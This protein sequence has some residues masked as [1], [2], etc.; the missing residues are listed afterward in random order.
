M[1]AVS[2]APT[3]PTNG[4]PGARNGRGRFGSVG[5]SRTTASCAAVKASRT[6]KLKRLA[7][8]TEA[9]PAASLTMS[10]PQA[11]V[12]VV[13]IDAGAS[14]VRRFSRSKRVREHAV[15]RQRVA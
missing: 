14:S 6:P 1:K 9:R 11:T 12:V 4:I 13:R 3:I 8:I 5:R 2:A 10:R 7:R 15:P